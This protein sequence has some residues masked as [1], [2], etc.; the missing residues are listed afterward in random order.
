[1]YGGGTN[2]EIENT[3]VTY[4][5]TRIDKYDNTLCCFK[6]TDTK[7][8]KKL[9][10]ILSHRC[11]ECRLPLWKTESS[12]YML[13]VKPKNAQALLITDRALTVC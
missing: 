6:I 13:K 3:N 4:I 9:S 1:M 7:A 2:I 11:E 10:P 12:E 5:S 8:K